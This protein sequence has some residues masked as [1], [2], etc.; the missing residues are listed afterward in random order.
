MRV[1]LSRIHISSVCKFTR[2]CIDGF[3]PRSIGVR[4]ATKPVAP[5]AG[6]L[7]D[8]DSQWPS[9]LSRCACR[10]VLAG[11]WRRTS[12]WSM[13]R[14]W[15]AGCPHLAHG[16]GFF[17]VNT[18]PKSRRILDPRHRGA[19]AGGGSPVVASVHCAWPCARLRNSGLSNT[20]RSFRMVVMTTLRVIMS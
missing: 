10:I 5:V 9:Y 14:R 20:S 11:M 1:R 16:R 6:N 8:G 7:V 13:P 18:A 4:W 2:S 17:A 15:A 3:R 12:V 19:S